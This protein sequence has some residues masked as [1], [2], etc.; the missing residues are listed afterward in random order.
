MDELQTQTQYEYYRG[1]NK[2]NK[3]MKQCKYCRQ[4]IDK[5]AK[6]CPFCRKKQGSGCLSVVVA[7]IVIAI[8]LSVI[9]VNM[10]ESPSSSSSSSSSST[11]QSEEKGMTESE[12][13]A[14][15]K[16]VTYE[17][18]AR[19]KDCLKGE[20]VSFTGEIIQATSG[21]YRMNITKSDFGLYSDTIMFTINES[22][23]NENILEDDIVTIWGES[24]GPYTYEAV[25]GNEITVPKIKVAYIENHGK[26]N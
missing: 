25:L 8:I 16:T 17:D 11:A 24:E 22:K 18:I 5:K 3:K 14:A 26:E 1:D 2:P 13:K 15:C 6:V 9:V 4:M 7:G 19:P 20:L 21:T 23:L 10:A 12:Y